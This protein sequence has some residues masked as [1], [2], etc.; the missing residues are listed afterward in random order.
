MKS[1]D[2]ALHMYI[3]LLVVEAWRS[4]LNTL[5]LDQMMMPL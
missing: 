4:S 3:F 5:E 1:G 2:V